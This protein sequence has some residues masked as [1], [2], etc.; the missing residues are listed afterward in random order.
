MQTS[1]IGKP[2]SQF[3]Q[4]LHG[5][6]SIAIGYMPIA[7]TYGFLA[8]ATGLSLG[9]TLLMSIIFGLNNADDKKRFMESLDNI[10]SLLLQE[11]QIT[12]EDEEVYDESD[13]FSSKIRYFQYA[14]D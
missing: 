7:I 12:F 13:D 3:K 4:G 5:G 2:I 1:V 10:N 8:K 14:G 9:E 11:E 6:L